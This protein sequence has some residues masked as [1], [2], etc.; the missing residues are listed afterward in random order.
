[1]R[2]PRH[3]GQQ[4]LGVPRRLR[5]LGPGHRPQHR[6]RRKLPPGPGVGVAGRLPAARAALHRRQAR[7][8]GAGRSQGHHETSVPVCI[9]IFARC[10]Y[11]PSGA[12][13]AVVPPAHLPLAGSA[14]ADQQRGRGVPG[15]EPYPGLE[16]GH[17]A[18]HALG[19][20]PGR[21]HV[22]GSVGVGG[23]VLHLQY[24]HQPAWL[25]LLFR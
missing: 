16:H 20:A 5:Q 21:A 18:G 13:P 6:T 9:N 14:R 12:G 8:G 24:L 1:M 4:G 7:P 10:K 19:P 23:P 15:L 11:F 3:A 17:A 22:V 2:R 25:M